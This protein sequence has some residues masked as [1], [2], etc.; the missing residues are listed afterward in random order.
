MGY[1]VVEVD[2]QDSLRGLQSAFSIGDTDSTET[3]AH[4]N[5]LIAFS[6]PP[7]HTTH[8]VLDGTFLCFPPPSF[9]PAD[10]AFLAIPDD[11]AIALVTTSMAVEHLANHV[12]AVAARG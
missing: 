7:P 12:A 2:S 9:W 6:V 1:S 10:H 5:D 8:W 11:V 4:S 3:D